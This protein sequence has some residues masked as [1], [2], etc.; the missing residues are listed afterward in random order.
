MD[1]S[2]DALLPASRQKEIVRYISALKTQESVTKNIERAIGFLMGGNRFL[3]R[4]K[5]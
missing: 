3:G 5:P 2:G 4:D 1:A